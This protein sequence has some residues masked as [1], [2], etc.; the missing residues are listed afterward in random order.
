MW[1]NNINIMKLLITVFF[2]SVV[3]LCSGQNLEKD[4]QKMYDKYHQLENLSMDVMVYTFNNE[5][6]SK[7]LMMKASLKKK[8]KLFYKNM[9]KQEIIV[10]K[11]RMFILDHENRQIIIAKAPPP[12]AAI[13]QPM[14]FSLDSLIKSGGEITRLHS[15]DNLIEYSI[16]MPDAPINRYI[17][18]MDQAY[19]LKRIQYFYKDIPEWESAFD[20]VEVLYTNKSNDVPA[21]SF[22]DEQSYV[23]QDVNGKLIPN[24]KYKNYEV[25]VK[26]YDEL[27]QQ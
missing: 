17:I 8:G 16:G 22:F 4:L 2:I 26:K 19:F 3:A 24:D 11:D 21:S 1:L 6:S 23:I 13:M 18:S 10:N 20:K 12:E 14:D 25:I 9:S 7:D 27:P 15:N 5:K